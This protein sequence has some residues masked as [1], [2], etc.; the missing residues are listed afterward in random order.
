MRLSGIDVEPLNPQGAARVIEFV[1]SSWVATPDERELTFDEGNHLSGA[2]RGGWLAA[3]FRINAPQ[4]LDAQWDEHALARAV[5]AFVARHPTLHRL[6]SLAGS[7]RMTTLPRHA[8][9]ALDDAS[10]RKSVV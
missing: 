4:Q 6:P 10:D 3:V 7:S 8:P 2:R 1:P 5:D 9:R